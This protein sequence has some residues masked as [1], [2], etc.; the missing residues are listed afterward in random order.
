M[1]VVSDGLPH[2]AQSMIQNILDNCDD[3]NVCVE[4][5]QFLT[6]YNVTP[7][8]VASAY[9]DSK[10]ENGSLNLRDVPFS[11]FLCGLCDS[12][13]PTQLRP[14][15]MFRE[16]RRNI[17][18][19]SGIGGSNTASQSGIS[20]SIL[21]N[22]KPF[23]TDK[24]YNF[25]SLYRSA[26]SIDY[27]DLQK[28]KAKTVLFPG[29]TLGT[30]HPKLTRALFDNLAQNE[31]DLALAMDCCYKPLRDIG[32]EDR[33]DSATQ[34]LEEKLDSMG[35]EKI[36]TAC[37]SCLQQLG[38]SLKGDRE[39]VSCYNLVHP[40]NDSFTSA[41]A[42]G[43]EALITIHDSCSDRESGVVGSE[44][45]KILTGLKGVRLTEMYHNRRNSLCC[46]S[47]GLVSA[48]DPNLA[49]E[50]SSQRVKEAEKTGSATMVTYCA[51][52]ADSFNSRGTMSVEVRHVLELLLG[53]REDYQ[54]VNKNVER[55]FVSGPKR[56]LFKKM[57]E[58]S[59]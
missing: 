44:V 18:R 13:C 29:C 47:G 21:S 15:A 46:G 25:Y 8:Q 27:S 56:E 26:N 32:L 24:K 19:E 39:V 16:L 45:R 38:Q 40:T 36:I 1:I 31:P 37:P 17:V 5:C 6:K 59:P 51:T 49:M 42:N 30:F 2:Q 23:F 43:S 7:A 28:S 22:C 3:C 33:F 54:A 12:F 11:C 4:E 52:C 48:F 55:L 14:T 41:E 57:I 10:L 50:A 20:S 9:E 35:V 34:K 58:N 53:V